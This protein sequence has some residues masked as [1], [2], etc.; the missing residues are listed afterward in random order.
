MSE[1]KKSQNRK[2]YI[3]LKFSPIPSHLCG[4][5][6][7]FQHHKACVEPRDMMARAGFSIQHGDCGSIYNYGHC[8]N[9]FH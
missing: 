6:G 8:L 7:T 5:E 4:Q 1:K 9:N 3:S 2:E